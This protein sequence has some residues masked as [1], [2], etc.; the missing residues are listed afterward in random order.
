[1]NKQAILHI[2]SSNFA[3][4]I[5]KERV[6]FRLRAGRGDLKS[7]TLFYGDRA[8]RQNPV[9]FT[10]AE[11]DV[12]AQD[13][14][15]DYFEIC[16][17]SPYTRICYYFELDDGTERTLYFYDLF[18]DEIPED[19]SELFQ[20]PFNRVEDIASIP[21]WV[22]DAVIYNIFPDSFATGKGYISAK[23]SNMKFGDLNCFSKL[24]GRISG[25]KENLDY[26]KELGVNCIYLNPIF[27]AGECH[28][29]DTIDYFSIDPCF[30]TNEDFKELVDECHKKGIRILIDGVFNHCGWNF[31]AFQDVLKNGE[32]SKYVKWF[33]ELEFP[34]VIPD[35]GDDIPNYS[36]FAYERKMPKLNTSNPE[37]VEYICKIC[38]FWLKNF[39]IDGWRLDVANEIDHDLWRSFRKTAKK[40]N[41]DCFIIGEVWETAYIWLLGDQFDSAMNYDLRKNCRDFMALNRLDAYDFDDRV[42]AMRMRYMKNLV[43]GQLNLLD[44]HDVSRFLSVCG[45]NIDRFKLAVIF[46]MTFIGAPSIFYGDEKGLTG[47]SEREYRRPM[48]WGEGNTEIFDFYKASIA[49]RKNKKPITRGEFKT[50]LAEKGSGLYIFKRF[51]DNQNVIVILNSCEK[52]ESYNF[53]EIISGMKCEISKGLNDNSIEAFGYAVFSD[54]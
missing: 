20:L 29:Y 15:F 16:L 50:I 49:L 11:M 10:S 43:F 26:I 36:C 24:G 51:L 18:A 1:M 3:H 25:V 39:N 32:N 28:K 5:D 35:N 37:V 52:P 41:P 13:K 7:C 48:D 19:R 44:S 34:V 33:Y 2:P 12:V 8:Y 9:L 14:Y 40:A 6:I 45:G 21:D 27:A 38:E 31:F 17:K 46:Q 30:G 22:H 42:T 53:S 23:E 54:C 47:V 4:G